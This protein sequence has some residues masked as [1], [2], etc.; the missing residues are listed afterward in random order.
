MNEEH[1]AYQIR[2]RLNAGLNDLPCDTLQKLAAAR[3]QALAHQKVGETQMVMGLSGKS[4]SLHSGHDHNMLR[5]A[6]AITA[7]VLGMAFAYYWDGQQS[8]DEMEA[9]D[10][11]LLSDELPP[12]A[13]LDKGFSAWLK[14]SSDQ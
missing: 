6:L 2:Q 1:F 13:Y 5:R 7:L 3:Q 8:L 10:S 9:L 4:H 12:E 14:R 11:A